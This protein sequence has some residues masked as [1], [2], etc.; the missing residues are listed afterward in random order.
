MQITTDAKVKEHILRADE[1]PFLIPYAS[2][3]LAFV[4]SLGSDYR[5]D[6]GTA[7][8]RRLAR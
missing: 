8:V 2:W 4:G 3:E 5:Q 6:S 7:C 1:L